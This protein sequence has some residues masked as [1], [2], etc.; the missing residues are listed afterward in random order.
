M[1]KLK[2]NYQELAFIMDLKSAEAKEIFIKEFEKDKV[3]VK[4]EIEVEKLK[5]KFGSVKSLDLR[6][7]GV[8]QL[9][10]NLEH[11]SNNYKKYL[12]VKSIVKRK[13]F[14]GGKT[15]FYKICNETQLK[16]AAERFDYYHSIYF[17][18]KTLAQ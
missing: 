9:V 15:V 2:L 4:D 16:H 7:D 11:K 8:N 14:N 13:K 5:Y 3:S 17:K 18:D 10:F 6:Y 1:E 12:S